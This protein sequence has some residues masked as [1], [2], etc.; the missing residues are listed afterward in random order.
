MQFQSVSH[1]RQ[2][3]PSRIFDSSALLDPRSNG[4]QKK[5]PVD[6]TVRMFLRAKRRNATRKRNWKEEGRP[7]LKSRGLKSAERPLA[8]L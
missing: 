4:S 6:S 1:R 2:P 5:S 7:D 3:D 8:R